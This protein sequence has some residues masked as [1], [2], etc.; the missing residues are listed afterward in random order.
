MRAACRYPDERSER[1]TGVVEPQVPLLARI[2]ER[3]FDS[4]LVAQQRLDGEGIEAALQLPAPV[5]DD[6]VLWHPAGLVVAHQGAVAVDR[7]IQ[8]V[9]VAPDTEAGIRNCDGRFG[10]PRDRPIGLGLRP[11][12]WDLAIGTRACEVPIAEGERPATQRAHLVERAAPDHGR[13]HGLIALPLSCDLCGGPIHGGRDPLLRSVGEAAIRL[14]RP[15]G[16][17]KGV[18]NEIAHSERVEHQGIVAALRRAPTQPVVPDESQGVAEQH[19]QRARRLNALEDGVDERVVRADGAVVGRDL[20]AQPVEPAVRRGDRLGQGAELRRP[21]H[22]P[23]GLAKGVRGHAVARKVGLV[24]LY[25]EEQR[26]A[27]EQPAFLVPAGAG[28]HDLAPGRRQD[29]RE[30]AAVGGGDGQGIELG[31]RHD[32]VGEQAVLRHGSRPARG[33]ETQQADEA[34]GRSRERARRHPTGRDARVE[35]VLLLQR[36]QGEVEGRGRAGGERP[37]PDRAHP[38]MQ[39][40]LSRLLGGLDALGEQ[41]D[42]AG[43]RGAVVVPVRPVGGRQ[44]VDQACPCLR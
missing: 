33:V 11:A 1:G 40:R 7:D 2:E 42:D 13:G 17:L 28:Q 27:A 31:R 29:G 5:E 24:G 14:K 25:P 9:D 16:A 41:G 3:R 22:Q 20:R 38:R 39:Q 23:I 43:E 26:A 35:T 4:H 36:L 8:P 6:V 34:P 12:E 37:P 30:V 44:P 21:R 32:V 18:V 15:Q 19:A 10:I